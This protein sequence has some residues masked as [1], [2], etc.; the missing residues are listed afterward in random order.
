[1][2]AKNVNNKV[3]NKANNK[4]N[5]KANSYIINISDLI[6]EIKKYKKNAFLSEGKLKDIDKDFLKKIKL[7]R[8]EVMQLKK[9]IEANDMELDKA[10]EAFENIYYANLDA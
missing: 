4:A 1:M 8:N 2:N 5:S 7:K 3:D 9:K 10:F 6:N